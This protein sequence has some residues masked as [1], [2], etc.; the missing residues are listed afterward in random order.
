MSKISLVISDIY[1]IKNQASKR[2]WINQIHPGSKLLISM[3]Y[4]VLVVS[5]SPY[6][7]IGLLGMIIYPLVVFMIGEIP[8]I[9]CLRR[10]KLILPFV[11]IVGIFN[12]FFNRE[13]IQSIGNFVI[14]AGMISMITLM[15][16]GFFTLIAIYLL[17][18]TTKVDN[19]CL[20]LRRLHVPA[21]LVDVILLTYR[22]IIVLMKEVER[23][24]QAY[25]LRAPKQKGIQIKVWGSL[26]GQLLLRSMDR[27]NEIYDSMCLRGSGVIE[28]GHKKRLEQRFI[29]KD[30]IWLVIWIVVL[31]AIRIFPIF[32]I[33]GNALI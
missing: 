23:M 28:K 22:Y 17:I 19:I 32:Q 2:I 15:F 18:I 21:I 11:V 6:N 16:K 8:F 33:V 9:D 13:P 27:A 1:K 31:L 25:S 29:L 3:L 30:L 20:A 26:V 5:F 7:V 14:S 4:M 24:V 12:P 10:I